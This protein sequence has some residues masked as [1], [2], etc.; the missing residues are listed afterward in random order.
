MRYIFLTEQ[1]YT[2]Y[3]HCTEIEQ[4]QSRPYAQLLLERNKI[5]FAVP[6]R[7]NIHHKYVLWSDKDNRCGLDFSK[8]VV[9][10]DM[11]YIDKTLIPHLRQNEYDALKNKDYFAKQKLQKYI[12]DYKRARKYP[13][14]DSSKRI[15]KY[16]ALQYFEEYL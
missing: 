16:S 14:K 4:K 2:D 12:H 9:I 10:I 13:D 7:S 11:K 3:A 1:F 6:L 5:T 15:L 8:A